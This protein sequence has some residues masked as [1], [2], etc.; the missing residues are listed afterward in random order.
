M[1]F[2]SRA[3]Q[4]PLT[5]KEALTGVLIIMGVTMFT[6]L[7]LSTLKALGAPSWTLDFTI[8]AICVGFIVWVLSYVLD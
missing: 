4:D 6:L 8:W 7:T 5:L 3:S 2:K 1:N